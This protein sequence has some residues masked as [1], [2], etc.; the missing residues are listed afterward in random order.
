MSAV[1]IGRLSLG[2]RGLWGRAE[3]ACPQTACSPILEFAFGGKW[4]ATLLGGGA[5]ARAFT[6]TG[7]HAV[8]GPLDIAAVGRLSELVGMPAREAFATLQAPAACLLYTSP[9]PRDS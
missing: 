7:E 2:L 4:L 1:N 9:S 8:H 6:F 5:C 3:D